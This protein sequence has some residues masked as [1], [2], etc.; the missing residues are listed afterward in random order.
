MKI[1]KLERTQFIKAS[2]EEAWAFFSSP[3]NLAKITPADM[4][5]SIISPIDSKI[6]EGQIIRYKVKVLP[7]YTTEWVSKIS[8]VNEPHSFV[9]EQVKG[10]YALWRHLHQFKKTQ[11]GTMVID[12]VQYAVPFGFLGKLANQYLIQSKLN[13]IFSYRAEATEKHL[14]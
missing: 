8:G 14:G 12:H 1:Y 6:Y 11:D 3:A 9:D 2:L 10:P 5:F 13:T 7:G 4:N